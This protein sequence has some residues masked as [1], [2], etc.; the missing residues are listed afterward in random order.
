MGKS[1]RNRVK[2]A[3]NPTGLP[4]IR[5]IERKESEL[6][7]SGSDHMCKHECTIQAVLEM[8]Q[9]PNAENKVIGL[10]TLATAFDVPESVEDVMKHKVVKVAAPLL[11]DKSKVV[12][13]AA[14]GALRNLSACG[15]YEI[16]NL[17][18]EQDVM[19]PLAALLQEVWN[20]LQ[21]PLSIV[22]VYPKHG[23]E[24]LLE[25]HVLGKS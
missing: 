2:R 14:A 22:F 8:L 6:G 24:F 10:Q 17:L 16:C 5:D 25:V 20:I 18:V 12:R 13:N 23:V 4:S 3:E 1:K 11:F 15:S 19:T 21:N 9:S 7:D